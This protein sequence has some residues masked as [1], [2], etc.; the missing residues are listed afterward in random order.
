M[1]M[2]RRSPKP[3]SPLRH[4]QKE[5]IRREAELR[6]RVEALE[7]MITGAPPVT[8]RGYRAVREERLETD[9]FDKR[10][11]VSTAQD[12]RRPG[13]LRQEKRRGRFIFLLLV[14]A[15]AVAVIWLM[16]HLPFD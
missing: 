15:L 7:R 8:H 2:F 12:R 3:T 14:V 11:Q 9:P 13:S 5:L 6:A 16:T 1:T 4:R 10:L